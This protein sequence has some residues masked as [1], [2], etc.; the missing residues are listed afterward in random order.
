MEERRHESR[1]CSVTV[2]MQETVRCGG[3]VRSTRA[4]MVPCATRATMR[5]PRSRWRIGDHVTGCIR[6]DG[7]ASLQSRQRTHRIERAHRNCKPR[8]QALELPCQRCRR[9]QCV[10]SAGE[11][12][13][14]QSNGR[15][16]MP[17]LRSEVRQRSLPPPQRLRKLADQAL[18][19]FIDALLLLSQLD[20]GMDA[21]EAPLQPREAIVVGRQASAQCCHE[22]PGY[23]RQRSRPF[24]AIRRDEFRRARRRRCPHVGDEVGNREIDFV[25]DAAH[26]RH[27][28]VDNCARHDFF[29]EG[30]QVLERSAAARDDE[31]VALSPLLTPAEWLPRSAPP[32]RLPAPAPG[33]SRRGSC[34]SGA[35]GYAAR[36]GSR[37][38]S[39]MSRR[40]CVWACAAADVCARWRTSLQRPALFLSSSNC[41][42]NAP[43]PA[44]SMK[45]TMNW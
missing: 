12:C 35:S 20:A 29:V 4:S 19:E 16:T 8:A 25:S 9:L 36:R 14:S 18:L 37:R 22:S 13:R 11:C 17:K 26:H 41:R 21:F 39:A 42:R 33:K 30:P 3:R 32:R 34:R 28:A 6:H 38:R 31:H 10:R 7:I 15:R 27:A 24:A 5:S 45:S 43:S 23:R 1:E 44:S 40:R 2:P